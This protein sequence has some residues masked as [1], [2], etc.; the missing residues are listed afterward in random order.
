MASGCPWRNA[1]SASRVGRLI[2]LEIPAT[3][4][5]VSPAEKAQWEQRVQRA[6]QQLEQMAG[7][8]A[9]Q[10]YRRAATYIRQATG[11]LFSYVRLWL[12]TGIVAPRT[13]SW[14][15]RLMRELGR[16]LKRIA[17]GWSDDGAAKMARI[18]SAAD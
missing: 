16:R 14:L 1:A 7:E 12:A 15:E 8:F 13:T 17:F 3:T 6:E 18:H 5:P 11:R 4:W 10:G 2:R 9:A